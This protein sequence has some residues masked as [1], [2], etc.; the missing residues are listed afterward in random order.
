MS[1]YLTRLQIAYSLALD[2]NFN[3]V[4]LTNHMLRNSI[5]ACN[6]TTALL[7]PTFMELKIVIWP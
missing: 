3:K 5:Y 4:F 7:V 6:T 1:H 2:T